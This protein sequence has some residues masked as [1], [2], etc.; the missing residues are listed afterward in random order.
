MPESNNDVFWLNDPSVLFR[1]GNY[2]RIIPS[3]NMTKNEVL[4]ALTRFFLY[5]LII[6][7]LFSAS[8]E[9]LYIPVIAIIVIIIIYFIQKNDQKANQITENFKEEPFCQM[10]TYDNPMMNVTLADLMDHRD[11]APACKSNV[12]TNQMTRTEPLFY[13]PDDVFNKRPMERPFY[14]MPSTTIP[15]NQTE[16][17]KWLY[18]L[19]ETC[20]ENQEMCLRYEDIRFTRYNPSLEKSNTQQKEKKITL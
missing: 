10:P 12:L 16:F 20:K 6:Y 19:P 4:N 18:P 14:T 9:Y 2:Y 13:D 1:N 11:R 15:N 5:L 3:S 17:A 8:K 7:L